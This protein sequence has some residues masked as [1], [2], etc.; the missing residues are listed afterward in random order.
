MLSA[1]EVQTSKLFDE[2]FVERIDVDRLTVQLNNLNI[3]KQKIK[4]LIELS[5]ALLKFQMGMDLNKNIGLDENLTMVQV[6]EGLDLDKVVD[7]TRRI[8]MDILKKAKS[9]NQ[10]DYER[11]QKSYLPTLTAAISTSLATQT[12]SFGDLF[13]Y[14]YFPT[15]A[16]VLNA[17]MPIYGGGARRAKMN[18]V[19]LNLLK[20][21]NDMEAF[22]QAVN[23]ESHNARTQLKNSIISL[24]NQEANIK[25]AEKVFDI[26]QKKF[27]EGVGTNI[28]IIQA[29]T[30]LKEAQTNYYN[31]L[32]EAVVAKIDFQ[33]SLGLLK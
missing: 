32:Y 11:Y 21:D 17:S 30:A 25:L 13:K 4:N 27:K 8:E 7:Y 16:F 26:A 24:E 29:E 12:Q 20:N 33:K 3:E 23:F 2:G 31:S 1:I 10:L 28:E 22:K 19:K 9:L 15:G 6:K 18:Q 14:S 5:Y